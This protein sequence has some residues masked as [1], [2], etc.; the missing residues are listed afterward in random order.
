MA[1]F[2]PGAHYAASKGF[3]LI[4]VMIA[5]TVFVAIAVTISQASSQSVGGLLTLQDTTLASFVAENRM[6]ELRL[7]GLPS[8]GENND[9]V[10]MANRDWRINTKV[11]KTEFPDTNRVTISVADMENKDNTIFSLT[12]I[13][14]AR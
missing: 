9:E 6:T 2:R 4:E 10:Q 12:S 14:G 1:D 3:T 5:L 8:V 7:T 13:M 11:E